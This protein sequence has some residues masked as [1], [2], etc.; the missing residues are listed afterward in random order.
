[1]NDLKMFL[2]GNR[3]TRENQKYAPTQAFVDE[4]GK[5]LEWEF[6]PLDS[7]EMDQIREDNTFEVQV[8]GK[9]NMYRSKANSKKIIE[10]MIIAATV[11]PNLYNQELQDSYGVKT[12]ND[13]L[14]ELIEVPGEYDDL[15]KFVQQMNGYSLDEKVEQAKN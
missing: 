3:K 9:P 12:P 13:L 6:R 1:M 10:D 15:G 7:K 4:N 14:H 2:K 8:T 5:A 11:V